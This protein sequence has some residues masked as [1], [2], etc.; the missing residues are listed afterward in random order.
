MK[1]FH[2]LFLIAVLLTAAPAAWAGGPCCGLEG[3]ASKGSESESSAAS[4]ESAPAA[5]ASES[6]PAPTESF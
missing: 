1:T 4:A 5:P 3:G 2:R 6:A